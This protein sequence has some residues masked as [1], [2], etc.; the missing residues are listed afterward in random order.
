MKNLLR[1]LIVVV[2]FLQITSC[3]KNDGAF[4]TTPSLKF[5]QIYVDTLGFVNIQAS[6]R[7]KQGDLAGRSIWFNVN[8]LTTTDNSIKDFVDYPMPD[9]PGQSNLA[10]TFTLILK[11]NDFSV[12]SQQGGGADSIYFD[13][14]LEDAAG[15]LSDTIRTDTIL[16]IR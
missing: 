6:F 8:N 16:V 5:E 13:L 11:Q 4:P 12:G 2:F 1:L 7:D 15:H 3:G 10:G 9:F 14:Y